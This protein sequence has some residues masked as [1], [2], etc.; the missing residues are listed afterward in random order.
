MSAGV[1]ATDTSHLLYMRCP[2]RPLRKEVVE[3][4]VCLHDDCPYCDITPDNLN[5]LHVN[6]VTH[7]CKE[8]EEWSDPERFGNDKM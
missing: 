4:A 2:E 7:R 8:S 1:H 3:A 6:T 5:K